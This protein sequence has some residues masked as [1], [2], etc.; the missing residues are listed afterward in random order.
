M[1][2]PLS[3]N[4]YARPGPDKCFKCNQLGQRSHQCSQRQMLNLIELKLEGA[5]KGEDDTPDYEEEE[6]ADADEGIP[7]FE[8]IGN[9]VFPFDPEAR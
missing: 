7:H 4:P 9:S 6:L 8:N 3:N 2:I 1:N 5:M